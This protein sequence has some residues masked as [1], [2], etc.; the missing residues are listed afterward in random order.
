[1]VF[2]L[3]GYLVLGHGPGVARAVWIAGGLA[4]A[5]FALLPPLRRP[6]FVAWMYLVF[7]IGWTVSHAIMAVLYFLLVTPTGLVRRLLVHDDPLG[8]RLDRTATTYW[9]ER[10]PPPAVERYLRQY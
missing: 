3:V 1:V 7:P 10:P 2:G 6:L 9:F 4:T 8:R 5:L